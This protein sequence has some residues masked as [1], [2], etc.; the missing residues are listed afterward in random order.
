[1]ITAG[2]AIEISSFARTILTLRPSEFSYE[3][4]KRACQQCQPVVVVMKKGGLLKTVYP[5]DNFKPL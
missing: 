5:Q 2:N 1:M 3:S 4:V